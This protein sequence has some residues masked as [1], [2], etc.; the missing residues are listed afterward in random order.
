MFLLLLL[1]LSYFSLFASDF[2]NTAAGSEDIDKSILR[3]N[4]TTTSAAGTNATV[5]SYSSHSKVRI[6]NFNFNIL[7]YLFSSLHSVYRFLFIHG[8]RGV[9][10]K[11]NKGIIYISTEKLKRVEVKRIFLGLEDL[12]RPCLEATL[13]ISKRKLNKFRSTFTSILQE[14]CIS[15][16][17]Y[18]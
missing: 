10:V 13:Y 14:F 8:E 6:M 12:L 11:I 2:A 7:S 5:R 16:I 4:I 17:A 9:Q 18:F 3:Q 15:N 1:L